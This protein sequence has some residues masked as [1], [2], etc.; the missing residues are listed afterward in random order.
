MRPA[1]RI[2]TRRARPADGPRLWA[3][4]D[5]PNIGCTEDP[6]LPIDLTIP[7]GPPAAF[8]DLA[9]VAASFIAPGGDFV[10]AE[11]GEGIVGMGGYRPDSLGKA[12]V[13]RV[14]V[15]P[16]VRRR[17]VGRAVMS[18]LE[19]RA[20]MAGF[21]EMHLDTATNQPEAIGFYQSLGYLEVGRETRPE[22]RWTLVYF[23]KPLV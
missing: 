10:V 2:T 18:E 3:L 17:G 19:A 11:D 13:L 7:D 14:R 4:N 1:Q 22:W 20:A 16:A 6:L 15:H 9:D 21:T 23:S 8:P 12:E 5:L